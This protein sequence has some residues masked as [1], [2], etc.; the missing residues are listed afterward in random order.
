VRLIFEAVYLRDIGMIERAQR[1]RFAR[2]ASA[3]FGIAADGVGQ[4]FQRN[5]ATEL[6]VARAIHLAHAAG[7]ERAEDLVVRDGASG[8][9]GHW[10]TG[11]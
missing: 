4:D 9:Q 3:A 7:A 1:P 2:K 5:V 8:R 6:G 11:E 10:R